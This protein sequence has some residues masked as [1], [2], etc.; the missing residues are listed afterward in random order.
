MNKN[1]AEKEAQR[2]CE[3]QQTWSV[4]KIQEEQPESHEVEPHLWKKT[5]SYEGFAR[6]ALEEM[7]DFVAEKHIPKISWAQISEWLSSPVRIVF[8]ENGQAKDT[9]ISNKFCTCVIRKVHD[10]LNFTIEVIHRCVLV[11]NP[12]CAQIIGYNLNKQ[13]IISEIPGQFTL[14]DVLNQRIQLEPKQKLQILTQLLEMTRTISSAGMTFNLIV[15]TDIF[16]ERTIDGIQLKLH[17]I[18]RL[19]FWVS[20]QYEKHN[21]H[22]RCHMNR[23]VSYCYVLQAMLRRVCT[24][25]YK[26]EIIEVLKP[27]EEFQALNYQLNLL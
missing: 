20:R 24:A 2:P 10:K 14:L 9:L 17:N 21:K 23:K 8:S 18:M 4:R 7:A 22:N 15:P 6:H 3:P 12:H 1:P 27:T 16:I 25:I 11:G 26:T 13:I 5:M 19:S